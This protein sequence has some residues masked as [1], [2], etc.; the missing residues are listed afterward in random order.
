MFG[1]AQRG[2]HLLGHVVSNVQLTNLGSSLSML[3]YHTCIIHGCADVCTQTHTQKHTHT[4]THKHSCCSSNLLGNRADVTAPIIITGP[5]LHHKKQVWSGQ[6]PTGEW[7][8]QVDGRT[9][10]SILT[11]RLRAVNRR[12]LL[13]V[14]KALGA[15]RGLG[16]KVLLVWTSLLHLWQSAGQILSAEKPMDKD[17][18]E[19]R[20]WRRTLRHA[21]Q[22]SKEERI[23]TSPVWWTWCAPPGCSQ[24]LCPSPEARS[25]G[26]RWDQNSLSHAPAEHRTWHA[27]A[28]ANSTMSIMSLY[29]FKPSY[30]NYTIHINGHK[31]RITFD[32]NLKLC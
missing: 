19:V 28:S 3:L 16:V 26:Q 10:L 27:H 5:D 13:L 6:K 9:R 25:Q 24:P 7:V 4:H 21:G 14:Q 11:L 8:K 29:Q 2:K 17:I 31:V 20:A 12:A 23:L 18:R 30:N 15:Q 1:E 22:R 32:P